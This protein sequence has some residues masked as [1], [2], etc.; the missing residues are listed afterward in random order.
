MADTPTSPA[1]SLPARLA[2]GVIVLYQKVVSPAL[3]VIAPS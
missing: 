1:V 3:V 2:E